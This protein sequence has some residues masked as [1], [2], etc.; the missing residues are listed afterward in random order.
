M[1]LDNKAIETMSVNA[2]KDS[3]V[4]SEL[5]DQFIADNDKEPSWDGFV[6]IYRNK[7]KKKDC[8]KGR[9]PVQVKGKECEDLSKS[10][11]TFS[12]PTVD[13]RNYLNDGGCVLF[14]VYIGNCGL[15]KKIYYAE[16]TPIKLRCLL[17]QAKE[18]D[19]KVIEL[20]EFPTDNNKKATI[21]LNC[22]Q[23]CQK[24]ASF[25]DGELLSLE[26]LKKQGVL[27]SIVIPFS[28]VGE[29]DPQMALINNEVYIYAKTKGSSIPQPIEIVPKDIHTKQVIDMIV[30]IDDR[31]FYTECSIVKNSEEISWYCGNSFKL[32]FTTEDKPY[33]I[34]YKNSDKIRV[35]AKDLDFIISLLDKGYFKINNVNI[36]F[37]YDEM[38]DT[39]FDIEK[40][41]ENLEFAKDI[42]KVLDMMNCDDDIDIKHMDDESWRNLDRLITA[43][44]KNK[45]VTDLAE[46]LPQFCCMKV[47]KL[48]FLIYLQKCKEKGV[49]E[50]YDFFKKEFEVAF[51]DIEGNMI[52]ISQ[53]S[54]LHTDELLKLDNI[55]FDILLPSFQNLEHHK[56]TFDRANCFL[57]ELLGAYDKA[58]GKRKDKL[59]KTCE[60]FCSWIDKAAED[61]IDYQVRTLNKLQVVKR[62]RD[63]NRDETAILYGMI[64]NTETREDGRVGAYLL[65]EQQKAAE[66][67]FA[68]LSEEEQNNFKKYPIYR[69]WKT[70]EN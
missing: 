12:M 16:L 65:L 60:K 27:E 11:I 3:I 47:G 33:K 41:R 44:I 57:L 50:I 23:N 14:V 68:K 61:E 49:Y 66:M 54:I 18:Q 29:K 28:G 1:G 58:E 70:E 43:L 51:K 20:K 17:F 26:E 21:F 6:Y 34:N 9:M 48:N 42:V 8:L 37:D 5:L 62:S 64:E 55:D 59:L 52:P 56:G 45:P 40:E 39:N 30:T 35:L 15:A 22:L 63:F 53:F 4:T 69:Y 32:N 67:H 25:K 13:L 10:K 24:Q 7:S 36:P 2:V 19:S 31:V 46:G 38:D